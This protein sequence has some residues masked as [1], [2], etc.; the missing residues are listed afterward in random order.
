M[1]R[2]LAVDYRWIRGSRTGPGT[3]GNISEKRPG[4]DPLADSYKRTRYQF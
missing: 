1:A 3:R 4:E 2:S